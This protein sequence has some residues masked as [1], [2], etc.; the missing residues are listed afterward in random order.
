[1]RITVIIFL[2]FF[3]LSLI[4]P[5]SADEWVKG[6][7]WYFIDNIK[8]LEGEKGEIL[9]WSALPSE[10]RGQEVKIEKIYPEPVEIIKDEINGNEIV[11]W[12]ITDFPEREELYF[13]Y[14]FQI[15]PQEVKTDIAPYKLLPWDKDTE[16]Y[17]RFTQSEP[18]IELTDDIKK[19]AQEIA[20]EEKNPYFQARKIFHWVVENI[21][22]EYPSIEERGAEI[23]FK[24]LKGDCGEFSVI[25]CALCR[26]LGIPARTVTC[27]WFTGGGHQWAEILLPPYGWI[28]IDPSVA[29]LMTPGS[30]AVSSDEEVRAFMKSRGIPVRDFSYLFGNLYPMRVIV[31]TGDNMEVFSK[32]TGIKRTFK[33][34]QPGGNNAYPPAIE[35]NGFFDKTV[36]GGFYI[37]GEKREDLDYARETAEKILASSYLT[38]GL[39]KKAEKGFLKIIEKR[40]DDAKSWL[41]LGQIY[42]N[43]ALWDEAIEA[44]KKCLTGKGGSTKSVMDVWAHNLLGNCYDIKGERDLAVKEYETVIKSGVDYNS[45]VDYAEKYLKEPFSGK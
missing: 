2:F 38:A 34:L 44:F 39:Y 33:F 5:S 16:E 19:K 28:P 41:S 24:K 27:I 31:S 18:W 21:E 26:S 23:S 7:Y 12:R 13:Y 40:P 17:K 8:L 45:A 6:R 14:D 4:L 3:L 30:K 25:F 1:M 22:Y 42:M 32:K 36:H 20:G 37:F 35:I 15:L 9:L 11:F 29:E 43:R 10:H